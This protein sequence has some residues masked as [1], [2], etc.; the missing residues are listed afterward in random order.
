MARKRIDVGREF[1]E[2]SVTIGEVQ[3]NPRR[4]RAVSAR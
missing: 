1:I 2:V 4:K 3:A